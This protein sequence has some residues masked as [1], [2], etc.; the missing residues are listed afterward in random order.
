MDIKHKHI[1]IYTRPGANPGASFCNIPSKSFAF[2]CPLFCTWIYHPLHFRSPSHPPGGGSLVCTRVDGLI[3]LRVYLALQPVLRRPPSPQV[4]LARSAVRRSAVPTPPTTHPT[5]IH[6]PDHCGHYRSW[7]GS[8]P[9][10][11]QPSPPSIP[12]PSSAPPVGLSPYKSWSPPR[13]VVVKQ[14]ETRR[15]AD[16]PGL[17]TEGRRLLHPEDICCSQSQPQDV[18]QVPF[19]SSLAV[20]RFAGLGRLRPL[21]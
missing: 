9:S 2:L 7:S 1:N 21:K 6:P 10:S 8:K 20:Q 15:G 11:F 4:T 5:T 19:C 3:G 12:H 18:Q 17:D 14:K 16:G 13:V